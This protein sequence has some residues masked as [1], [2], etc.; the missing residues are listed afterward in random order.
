MKQFMM[1]F[2]KQALFIAILSG[3]VL[4]FSFSV[5]L[6]MEQFLAEIGLTESQANKRI[7]QAILTGYV[8][9]YRLSEAR[10]IPLSNHPA[11]VSAAIGFA[12]KYTQSAAF[13]VEYEQLRATNKPRNQEKTITPEELRT[14]QINGAK[15]SITKLEASLKTAT[16][17]LKTTIESLLESAKQN[18]AD[19]QNPDNEYIKMYAENYPLMVKADEERT[20]TQLKEWELKYPATME[21]YL[22]QQLELFLTETET[23]DFKAAT[24]LQGGKQKFVNKIYEGKSNHWKLAYRMGAAAIQT[25]RAEISTWIKELP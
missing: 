12:K 6:T 5:K 15:E 14:Q 24:T 7:S 2:K 4:I 11:I 22:K 17:E 23:V 10:K 18:L 3:T 21:K 16:G 8:N 19:A 25:A 1:R 20:A 13:K 9:T